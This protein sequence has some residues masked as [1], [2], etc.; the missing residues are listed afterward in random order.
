VNRRVLY[1]IIEEPDVSATLA[2]EI[3]ADSRVDDVFEALTWR[4]ARQPEGPD[5]VVVEH[6]G[7]EYRLVVT[8]PNKDAQNPIIL[9]KYRVFADSEEVVVDWIKVYPYDESL[10][11]KAKEFG[12]TKQ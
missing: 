10:A 5:S 2:K 4:L 1:T 8:R 7:V 6:E 3:Q 11:Y 9:A 12:P